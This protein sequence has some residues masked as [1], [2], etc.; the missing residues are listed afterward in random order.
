M[1]TEYTLFWQDTYGG[2]LSLI[3]QLHS[4]MS[5]LIFMSSVLL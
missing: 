1:E 4:N 3:Q 2:Q 5:D